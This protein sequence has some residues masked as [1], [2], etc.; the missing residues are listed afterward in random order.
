M[1]K[2]IH[3]FNKPRSRQKIEISVDREMDPDGWFLRVNY[4]EIK[5]NKV[6]STNCIILKDLE[7]WIRS[8][9]KDGWLDESESSK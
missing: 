5:T 3:T 8:I 7:T 6:T 4:I 9:K 2:P 1:D